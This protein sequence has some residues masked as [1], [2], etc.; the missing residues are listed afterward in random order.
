MYGTESCSPL[1][2][3][4]TILPLYMGRALAF[5]FSLSGLSKATLRLVSRRP[6]ERNYS[7]HETVLLSPG[8]REKS[9]GK[10]TPVT[11]LTGS[12]SARVLILRV[13]SVLFGRG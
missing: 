3:E 11:I 9:P 4:T 13:P 7:A 8:P 5:R 12:S 6:E 1:S 10:L 2:P